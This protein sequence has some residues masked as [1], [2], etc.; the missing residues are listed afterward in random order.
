MPEIIEYVITRCRRAGVRV[1][2][3]PK[4]EHFRAYRGVTLITPNNKEA[5]EGIGIPIR[6]RASLERAGA[7]IREAIDPEILLVTRSEHGIALFER[8]QSLD[9]IPTRAQ[10]VFDV[11]GGDLVIAAI[12][13]CTVRS[14]RRHI[15]ERVAGSNRTK[16]TANCP[17]AL[18]HLCIC[19]HI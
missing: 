9:E 19:I 18:K 16:L 1:A 5:S 6:D 14:M 8:G 12:N 10:E 4:V 17:E 7:A 11:T 15:G 3:D 2:V 13:P